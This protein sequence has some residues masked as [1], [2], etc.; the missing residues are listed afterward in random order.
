MGK[1][2]GQKE[3]MEQSAEAAKKADIQF[4]QQQEYQK[5]VNPLITALLGLGISPEQFMQ[6][7]LG[8]ALL[9]QQ[10]AGISSEFDAAR[11]NLIEGLGST[12]MYGSGVGVG[13]L[14]NLY[15]GEA[16]AQANALQNT[17]MTGL[18]LGFQGANM[19]QGQQA[20]LDTMGFQRTAVRG[21]ANVHQ[22]QRWN[23]ILGA[24]GSV[25]GGPFGAS[26]G[27]RGGGTSNTGGQTDAMMKSYLS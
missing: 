27:G 25:L 11:Q 10:R 3:T 21:F 15:S 18:N 26:L 7:S 13:P 23:K 22:A 8:Q 4:K 24:A 19:L 16:V 12:G 5:Q 9:G 2:T 6:S 17:S 1:P 14:A 20:L